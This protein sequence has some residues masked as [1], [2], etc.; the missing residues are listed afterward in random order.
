[1][2][3]AHRLPSWIPRP[4][5]RPLLPP[6]LSVFIAYVVLAAAL[7]LLLVSSARSDITRDP[8]VTERLKA[9]GVPDS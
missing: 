4:I 3:T 5:D 1:M 2:T 8:K 6:E 9:V 7:S